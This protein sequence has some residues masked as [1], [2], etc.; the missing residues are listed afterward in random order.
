M[1]YGST[2]EQ[3]LVGVST[4][5]ALVNMVVERVKYS[6]S[7]HSAI[8]AALPR[9]YDLWRGIYSGRWHPHKNVIHIPLIYSA[10][11]ADAARKAA[12]SLNTYPPLTFLGYGP[13]D[14]SVARKHEALVAAQMKDD[15]VYLKQV[16]TF[17]VADLH[18]TAITQVGWKRDAPYRIIETMEKAP[19]SGRMIRLIRK[20]E[21]V[22]YDGPETENVDRIDFFPQPHVKSIKKMKWVVRRHFIDIDDARAL[23]KAGMF[24]KA[25]LTR[26]E[27]EGGVNSGIA[28]EASSIHRFQVR[29]GLDDESARWMDKY[30]RPIELLEYWGSIPSEMVKDGVLKRVVTVANRRYLFRN[31]PLPFYHDELPFLA[32]SPTPD[33]YYFDAPGKAEV[34]EKVQIAANRYLNQ[35]LD[36]ADLIIDPVWFYDRAAN[37]NTKNLYFY[38]GRFI[39]IDGN[40]GESVQALQAPLQNL[41]VADT[42]VNFLRQYLQMGTGIYD[43]VV[44]GS[45]GADR[46]T[47]R[48]FI[49][50]REAA[51]TRLL[52][53]SRIYEEMYLER[54][55]NFFMSLNKQ[56]LDLPVQI[57]MLGDSAT[58]DPVTG[59]PIP[60]TRETMTDYDLM[61][62]YSARAVG[63]T[64][65]LSRSVKQQN[66]VQLLQAMSATPE[67]FGA[68]NMI[69]FWRGIFREFEIPNI[70][71]LFQGAPQQN[72][73]AAL[74]QQATGGQGGVESVPTSGQLR[75]GGGQNPLGNLPGVPQGQ[76][77]MGIL[78]AT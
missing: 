5:E 57:N 21:V 54:L 58:T 9:R 25:E 56:F 39:P 17:V 23:A 51:G 34:V 55:G 52:L 65:Q 61:P 35:S 12:T 11:W 76:D 72:P 30:N 15:D 46:Q 71:E 10:I 3:T 49:G 33:P 67:I 24:D 16:D 6:E 28:V 59:Q 4:R 44:Q 20:G 26:L 38:P 77:L 31:K 1:A 2:L 75:V 73:L 74:V 70:N 78:Q 62:S 22:M 60:T 63:A 36:A 14:V 37:L 8:L 18:G 42:R 53:E 64:S 32:F 41:T 48:E 13:D 29:T 50:R 68:I 7:C 19:I 69:N 43:D 47:A 27:E 40:P 45:E 66:L